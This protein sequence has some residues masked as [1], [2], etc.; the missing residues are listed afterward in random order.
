MYPNDNM[1]DKKLLVSL[2]AAAFFVLLNLPVVYQ[3]TSRLFGKTWDPATGCATPFGVVLHAGVFYLLTYFSM[4]GSS[5][6]K[7]DKMKHS[8][9][10]ALIFAVLGSAPVYRLTSRLV[11]SI[12]SPAGCPS[13]FGVVAHGL[14]F[15]GILV[16]LMK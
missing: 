16:A 12:A 4:R 2:K 9:T 15:A 13:L 7:Q 11:P 5:V 1:L 6:S 3:T 8:L 14:V 10:G